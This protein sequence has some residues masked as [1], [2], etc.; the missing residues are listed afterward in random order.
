LLKAEGKEKKKK[1]FVTGTADGEWRPLTLHLGLWS[2]GRQFVMDAIRRNT[3]HL[4]AICAIESAGW[5]K[6]LMQFTLKG[7]AWHGWRS[8]KVIMS[9]ATLTMRLIFLFHRDSRGRKGAFNGR[10]S[11]PPAAEGFD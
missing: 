3:F 7:S 1:R 5:W 11:W 4:A 6:R 8:G 9:S 10:I 2:Y